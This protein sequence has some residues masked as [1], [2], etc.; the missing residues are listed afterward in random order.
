MFKKQRLQAGKWPIARS[1][2]A[3]CK[4]SIV[5]LLCCYFL[6]Q[7]PISRCFEIKILLVFFL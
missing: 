7:L 6:W 1:G 3:C 2:M 4:Y 5:Q